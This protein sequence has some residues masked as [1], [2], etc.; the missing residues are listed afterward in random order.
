MDNNDLA[1]VL[2]E[3]QSRIN[4]LAGQCRE[5]GSFDHPEATQLIEDMAVVMTDGVMLFMQHLISEDL[6]S[7]GITGGLALVYHMGYKEGMKQ[8]TIDEGGDSGRMTKVLITAAVDYLQVTGSEPA[9]EK[10][11]EQ[12][13]RWW[14][15]A[16]S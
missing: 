1:K 9:P 16:G 4:K 7:S 13:N 2:K 10:I 6:Q 11:W 12:T 3:A 14:E 8:A 5:E 15:R